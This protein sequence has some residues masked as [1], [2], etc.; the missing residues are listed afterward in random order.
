MLGECGYHNTVEPTISSILNNFF[1]K[2][3]RGLLCSRNNNKVIVAWEVVRSDDGNGKLM[4]GMY[5]CTIPWLSS[6]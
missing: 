5:T 3:K 2:K 4:I 1:F 6:G